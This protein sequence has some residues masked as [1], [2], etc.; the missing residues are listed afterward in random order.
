MLCAKRAYNVVNEERE[1]AEEEEDD[2]D[3]EGEEEEEG[4]IVLMNHKK[5]EILDV[6][7]KGYNITLTSLCLM[8]STSLKVLV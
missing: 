1:E 6:N 3:N 5:T 8:Y 4:E 7:R 2:E